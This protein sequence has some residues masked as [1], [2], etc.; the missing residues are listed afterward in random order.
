M[1][2]RDYQEQAVHEL[3]AA[4]RRSGSVVYQLA[5]GAGKTPVAGEIARLAA[6]KGSRTIFLAIEG[7]LLSRR[8]IRSPSYAP[9]CS[10]A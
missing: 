10:L 8:W 6:Q 9:T 7:N 3:R 1:P 4:V 5:T 2:L